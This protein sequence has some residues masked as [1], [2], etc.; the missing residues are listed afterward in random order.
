MRTLRKNFDAGHLM[1]SIMTSGIKPG[2]LSVGCF[3]LKYIL[4]YQLIKFENAKHQI[5]N[6]LAKIYVFNF[7]EAI[8]ILR[9]KALPIWMD[10]LSAPQR[11]H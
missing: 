5:Q 8:N 4:V 9:N 2:F 1:L 3:F 11:R 10:R 6:I 7:C